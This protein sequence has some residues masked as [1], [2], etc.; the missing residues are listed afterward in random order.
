MSKPCPAP[1][2]RKDGS[3]REAAYLNHLFDDDP[4]QR[5]RVLALYG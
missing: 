5:S 2:R 4:R 1:C 3:C